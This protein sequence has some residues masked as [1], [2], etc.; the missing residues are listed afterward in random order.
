MASETHESGGAWV[1]DLVGYHG[2][3]LG[4]AMATRATMEALRASGR[5]T[6]LVPVGWSSGAPA[7]PRVRSGLAGHRVTLFEVNPLEIAFLADQWTRA[8]DSTAPAACV[9]FWELPLVPRAWMPVLS[10]MQA[11]LAPTRFVESACK[12]ALPSTPV[13]HFPQAAF[14]P[15]GI[16]PARDAWGLAPGRTAFVVAFDVGSDIDR[17]NP[18]AA[19][20]AFQLAFPAPE[21]GVELVVKVTPR[22]HVPRYRAQLEELRARVGEDSRIR[23]VDQW[24]SYEEVLCLYASCDVMVSLHR[25]EGLGLHLMEAM[26]LERAVVATGWSGNMDFM[27]PGNS[28]PIAYRLVPIHSRHLAYRGE[29]GREGQ[30]WAEPD[31]QAAVEALRTLH[32]NRERRQNLGVAAARDMEGRRIE[33]RKAKV[34]DELEAAL[35]GARGD[36]RRLWRARMASLAHLL[37][38]KA[39]DLVRGDGRGRTKGGT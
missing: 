29:V 3:N 2:G 23:I 31:P 28:L 8:I 13:L 10:A 12:V 34:L 1:Y 38:R 26:S 20:K 9:P 18:W 21:P 6:N 36:P 30:L 19:V 35:D 4:I 15:P 14:L 37:A 39:G 24:L 16:A 25:S 7:P 11:V 5:I 33:M 27:A 17:K 32:G 22:D